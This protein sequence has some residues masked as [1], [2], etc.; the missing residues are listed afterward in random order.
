MVIIEDSLLSIHYV[1]GLAAPAGIVYEICEG[2]YDI[3]PA[4][5]CSINLDYCSR[6]W[7]N[8]HEAI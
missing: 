2:G 8:P 5:E 3:S 7:N 1:M 4:V 6:Y